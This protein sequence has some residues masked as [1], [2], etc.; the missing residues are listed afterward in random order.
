MVLVQP[1]RGEPDA[2]GAACPMPVRRSLSSTPCLPGLTFPMSLPFLFMQMYFSLSAPLMRT[3][4]PNVSV[5]TMSLAVGEGEKDLR[6]SGLP[7]QG[8]GRGAPN[9]PDL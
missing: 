4:L 1:S 9:Q 3:R 6:L 8:C 2:A 7:A 5:S